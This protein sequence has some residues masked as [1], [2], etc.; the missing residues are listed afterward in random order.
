[1]NTLKPW[2]LVGIVVLGVGLR[3]WGIH[4]GLPYTYAPDEPTYLTITLQILRSGD[5]NPHWWYYPSAM[6]YLHALAQAMFFLLGRSLGVFMTLADLPLPEIITTGVGRTTLPETFLVARGLTALFSTLA[7]LVVYAMGRRLHSNPSVALLAAFFFAI[8]P[9]VNDTSHRIGPDILAMFFLLVSAFFAL[10]LDDEP[11]WQNYVGAGLCAGWAFGSK[12][13]AGMVIIALLVAHFLRWRWTKMRQ[14]V[15][16]LVAMG[17]G[18]FIATPFAVF[19]FP[20]FWEG[21]RWQVFSYSVEGH[22]GQ[23]GDALRWYLTYLWQVEGWVAFLGALGVLWMVKQR[24]HKF[25]TFLSFPVTYFVFISLMLTRNERTIMLIVPF[26][27]LS[28]AILLVDVSAYLAT[29]TRLAML[30]AAVATILIIGSPLHISLASIERLSTVDSRETARVWIEQNLPRGARLA[31][32][33]YSPYV[34][35]EQFV[36]EPVSGLIAHPPEWYVQNGFEYLVASYGTYGRFYEDPARYRDF[37]A[38]YEAFFGYL[39]EIKRFNDG[40]FEIR[41]YQTN[42]MN[43]PTQ[44]VGARWGWYDNWL[45]LV[46]YDSAGTVLPGEML[47]VMLHWRGLKPR[48]EVF[49]LTAR[50]LDRADHEIAQSSGRLQVKFEEMTRGAWTIPVPGMPRPVSIVSSWMWMQRTLDAC[51][52]SIGS[53]SRLP[54]RCSSDP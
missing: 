10:R 26:L 17:V 50:L 46:G 9:T 34:D 37:V 30:L 18:F 11:H 15:L 22:S 5:L 39:P 33:P 4:F 48:R 31:I 14:L 42:A 49:Q 6:F 41:V 12:Y 51:R 38:R 44:R 25:W 3:F 43:L 1:M 35:R 32:E 54:T 40:G 21:L 23:E 28:A 27:C 47:Q 16:A 2:L 24:S 13:N 20:N 52:C 45:E 7:I 19:D 36:V 8:S 29:R 53:E